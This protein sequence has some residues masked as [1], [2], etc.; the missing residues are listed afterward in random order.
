MA[1]LQAWEASELEVFGVGYRVKCY[2]SYSMVQDL[3]DRQQQFQQMECSLS[4]ADTKVP[5]QIKCVISSKVDSFPFPLS[6]VTPAT[7][8]G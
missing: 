1:C 8:V 6:F 4:T 5:T 7:Q 3:M 2:G